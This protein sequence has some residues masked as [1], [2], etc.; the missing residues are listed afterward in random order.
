[1]ASL[2][3]ELA[4]IVI[5]VLKLAQEARSKGDVTQIITF[6]VVSLLTTLGSFIIT[7]ISIQ[8]LFQAKVVDTCETT[9]DDGQASKSHAIE[10][11]EN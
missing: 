8:R 7:L 3:C 2:V 6:T 9:E 5:T 10:V 11:N 1:M 4:I